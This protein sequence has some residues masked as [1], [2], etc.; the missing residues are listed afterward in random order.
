MAK[1]DRRV[2]L[3]A[4]LA[5]GAVESFSSG[6]AQLRAA[7]AA[8]R[9]SIARYRSSPAD[10]DGIKEEARRLTRSAVD[11]LGGMKRFVAQSDVVWV[12]PNIAWSRRPEQAATTNPDVV[13]TIVRMCFEAGAKEVHVGDHTSQKAQRTLPLSGIQQAAEAEGARVRILDQRKFRTMDLGG[14]VLKSWAVYVD[15][16]EVDKLINIPI[17]KHHSH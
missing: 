5:S 13:A 4:V 16:V 7:V 10:E 9:L 15:M 14:K 11:A 2:F 6:A 3:K 8:P 17:A 12:K 1:C